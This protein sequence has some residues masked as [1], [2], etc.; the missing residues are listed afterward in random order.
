MADQCHFGHIAD[1]LLN[2]DQNVLANL[3]EKLAKG[4]Q[5][6]PETEAEKSYFHVIHDLDHVAGKMH[7][8]T[9]SKKYMRNEIWSLINFIGAPYWYITY[10]QQILNI[11]F[12]YI[13]LIQ[14]KNSN[15]KFCLMT[16]IPV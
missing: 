14:M 8:S 10:H 12:A 7:G 11:Q 1:W 13:M 16:S 9:T 5:I 15:L 3:T 6:K 4:Q 2:I